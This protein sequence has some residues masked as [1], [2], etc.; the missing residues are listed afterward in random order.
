MLVNSDQIA[1]ARGTDL[2]TVARMTGLKLRRQ[3]AELVGPCPHYGGRDRVSVCEPSL[4]DELMK[5][6]SKCRGEN[7][8]LPQRYCSKCHAAYNRK[9]RK[10]HPHSFTRG[11]NVRRE[12]SRLMCKSA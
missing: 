5:P 8:R 3:G 11:T 7:D 6:C 1:S 4:R 2:S 9:W 12:T 10:A